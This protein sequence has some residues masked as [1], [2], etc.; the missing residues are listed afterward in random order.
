MD[1]KQNFSMWY[2]LSVM[3]V[4]LALQSILY[5]RHVESLAYSDFKTLLRAG[6]ITEVLIADDRLTGTADLRGA[7]TLLPPEVAK[8][9][10]RDDLDKH[11]FVSARVPD[12][13]LV[14]ELQAGKVRFS[15]LVQ[16]G[17]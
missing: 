2:F 11:P 17:I 16:H 14:A 12:P 13:N 10:P 9:L 4:M 15:A 8:N 5:N 3:V 6:K 1:Q 7:A